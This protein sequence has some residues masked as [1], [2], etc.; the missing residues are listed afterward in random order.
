MKQLSYLL[1]ETTAAKESAEV[2]YEVMMAMAEEINNYPSSASSVRQSAST[3][4]PLFGWHGAE[5]DW[6][7]ERQEMKWWDRIR[8]PKEPDADYRRL[9]TESERDRGRQLVKD[10]LNG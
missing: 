5:R 3:L 4:I 10:Y 1:Q 8:S 9:W 7:Q 6:K 2:Q